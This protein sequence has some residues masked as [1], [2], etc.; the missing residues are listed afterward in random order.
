MLEGESKGIGRVR[1]GAYVPGNVT[2]ASPRQYLVETRSSEL[3]CAP[4]KIACC[5]TAPIVS[6]S[7]NTSAVLI[8]C[9]NLRC[10]CC[11]QPNPF[12]PLPQ[13]TIRSR[14]TYKPLEICRR[15]A[16]FAS[17]TILSTV[18]PTTTRLNAPIVKCV[19]RSVCTFANCK[20]AMKALV[21]LRSAVSWL[22]AGATV[23]LKDWED[24]KRGKS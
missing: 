4:T 15:H 14:S 3:A 10:L 9:K 17:H 7:G 13:P 20:L 24:S 6:T 2:M 1:T 19:V 8:L 12:P 16:L 5:T 11:C 21:A 22:K 23:I 18:S